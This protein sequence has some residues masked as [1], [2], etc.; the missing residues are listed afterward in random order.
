MRPTSLIFPHLTYQAIIFW[1]PLE[2]SGTLIIF[3]QLSKCISASFY[4]L[5]GIFLNIEVGINGSY[6]E[7]RYA[8]LR[9]LLSGPIPP[10]ANPALTSLPSQVPESNPS[11]RLQGT[12]HFAGSTS[13]AV[14]PMADW[15]GEHFSAFLD[16]S[17][18]GSSSTRA[19]SVRGLLPVFLRSRLLW[20]TLKVYWILCLNSFLLH[21]KQKTITSTSSGSGEGCLKPWR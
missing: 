14:C 11:L 15:P 21:C 16:D 7:P 12:F 8:P 2:C 3:C 18:Y 10:C 9:R 20:S 19:M 4:S 13:R 17:L 6:W 1:L 5:C